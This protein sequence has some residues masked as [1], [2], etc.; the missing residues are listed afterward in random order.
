MWNILRSTKWNKKLIR[1]IS[2]SSYHKLSL[3]CLPTSDILWQL[4]S[5]PQ[6][7]K[8]PAKQTDLT[9]LY[10]PALATTLSWCSH[11]HPP[12]RTKT[13]TRCP[14]LPSHPS[15]LMTKV[16]LSAQ[17]FTPS[18]WAGWHLALASTEVSPQREL[19]MFAFCFCIVC[20]EDKFH[21]KFHLKGR[22]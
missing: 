3:S 9:W 22:K 1:K 13:S 20:Q 12:I 18:V 19:G 14:S 5:I 15:S 11:Q 4:D 6:S 16:S 7:P 10:L 17:L 8:A 2:N 21:F